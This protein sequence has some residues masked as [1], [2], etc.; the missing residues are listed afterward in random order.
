MK[1]TIEITVMPTGTVILHQEGVLRAA[2][3]P[4]QVCETLKE[5]MIAWAKEAR[6]A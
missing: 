3:T 4:R 6:N 2:G 1:A 5:M